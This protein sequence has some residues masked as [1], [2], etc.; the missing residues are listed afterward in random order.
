MNDLRS[1][2]SSD[3]TNTPVPS[4]EQARCRALGRG[5][6]AQCGWPV[7]DGKGPGLGRGRGGPETRRSG[8]C[9]QQVQ[10]KE[11]VAAASATAPQ[12]AA[13]QGK[14]HLRVL[15]DAKI[16]GG[17]IGKG[18]ESIQART[19]ATN[20]SYGVDPLLPGCD[21]RVIGLT[22][23]SLECVGGFFFVGGGVLLCWD[24]LLLW[25]IGLGIP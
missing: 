23:N 15:L 10:H 13:P 20:T 3:G 4:S 18:G 14:A 8:L 17:F 24:R 12:T 19:R 21:S 1:E 16:V 7:R 11:S 2:N 6:C 9:F 22:A 25:A 5:K